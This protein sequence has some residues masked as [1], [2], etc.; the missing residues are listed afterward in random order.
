M[1]L[2]ILVS[3]EMGQLLDKGHN[4]KSCIFGVIQLFD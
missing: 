4:S 2:G 1:K 3:H